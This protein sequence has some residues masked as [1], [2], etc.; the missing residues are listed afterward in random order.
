MFKG[1][2]SADA[3]I[4]V[5]DSTCDDYITTSFEHLVHIKA[6]GIGKVIVAINKLDATELIKDPEKKYISI[7]NLMKPKLLKT[8]FNHD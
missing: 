5:V 4:F 6:M 2:A 1:L 8:G 7:K 3:A